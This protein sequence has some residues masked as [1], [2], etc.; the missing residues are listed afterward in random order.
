MHPAIYQDTAINTLI[1]TIFTHTETLHSKQLIVSQ[2]KF[3]ASHTTLTFSQKPRVWQKKNHVRF[4]KFENGKP[5]VAEVRRVGSGTTY[6]LDAWRRLSATVIESVK[7]RGVTLY[8]CNFPLD[9]YIFN[10]A[11]NYEHDISKNY[12]SNESYW[13]G[14]EYICQSNCHKFSTR[15]E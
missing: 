2:Q 7:S 10:H 1:D 13:C 12:H 6:W 3:S 8:A 5:I 15:M 9:N 11:W 4:S 14:L